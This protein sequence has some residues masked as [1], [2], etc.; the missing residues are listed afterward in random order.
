MFLKFKQFIILM[1]I[2][3]FSILSI[4]LT[5]STLS[6]QERA[7]GMDWDPEITK[8]SPQKI[9]LASVSYRGMPSAYSL[10]KYTP[11]VGDQ[12]NYGTCNAF[13]CAYAAATMVFAQTHGISDKATIDKCVFSPTFL[14]QNIV[15]DGGNNCQTGSHP[16]TALLFM[17]EKGLPFDRTVPYTCGKSWSSSAEME[18]EKYKIADAALL[19]G[20][21]NEVLEPDFKVEAT[22][23]ALLENTPVIIGF[24]LPKSFFKVTTDTWNPDP[25][26]ALGNWKHGKHAMTV[27]AYDDYKAGGAFK[28]LNSWGDKW[29]GGG[30]VWIKYKDYTRCCLMALQPFGDPNAPMP[31]FIEKEKPKPKIEPAP[32]PKPEPTPQPK[33][34]PVPQPTPQYDPVFTL[35]G[36]VEF[37]RNTGETMP[38]NRISTRNLVVED[39]KGAEDLAAYRMNKSYAS[40]TKFRF[41]ININQEAYIYAF[42]TDLTGKVNRIMPYD[43]LISTH[44]GANSVVAFPSEK[45]VVKMDDN[46]GT[47]YMLILYSTEKLD[48]KVIAEKMSA[49]TGGL[50]RKIKVALGDKLIDKND[51]KYSDAQIGFEFTSKKRGG[52]VP[53]MVELSHE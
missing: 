45:K 8:K 48:S 3:I 18:A 25:A 36:S 7:M 27:I 15:K 23:K 6:A 47:D 19:F 53:L 21:D 43:D 32:Q 31:D 49:T 9:Q 44:L 11:S 22:K 17:N 29:G 33:P 50:S 5:I 37:K 38:A 41:L 34:Q 39:E 4:Y 51:V 24:E 13:A 10:E 20:K 1:R 2:H 14:Y 28:V 35:K 12:G 16:V 40:G 46:K 52:V 26:E 42:A 30:S